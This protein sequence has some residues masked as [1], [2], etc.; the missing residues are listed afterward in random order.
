M[1][2]YHKGGSEFGDHYDYTWGLNT[3]KFQ[4]SWVHGLGVIIISSWEAVV[5]SAPVLGNKKKHSLVR[6]NRFNC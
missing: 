6:L 5:S 1:T 4:T 2:P 3:T